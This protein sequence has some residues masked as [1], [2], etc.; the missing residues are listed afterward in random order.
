MD[1]PVP[2]VTSMETSSSTALSVSVKVSSILMDHVLNVQSEALSNQVM[3][4]FVQ[5]N[6]LTTPSITHHC[7]NALS[8]VF[9][10]LR[11]IHV[12][13]RIDMKELVRLFLL[14][15]LKFV[16]YKRDSSCLLDSLNVLVTVISDSKMMEAMDVSVLMIKK[17]T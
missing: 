4:V 8:I 16:T 14:S 1:R 10:I 12:F 17:K 2:L 7:V 13:V 15:V 5:T 6:S 11:I 3:D 9:L